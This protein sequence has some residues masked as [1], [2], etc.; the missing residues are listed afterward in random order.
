MGQAEDHLGRTLRI[1]DAT[2]SSASL[3]TAADEPSRYQSLSDTHLHCTLM[4]VRM[5]VAVIR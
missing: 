1:G 5:N 4:R 2:E 3:R